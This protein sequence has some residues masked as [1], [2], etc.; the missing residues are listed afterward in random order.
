MRK[1]KF[2]HVENSE[3]RSKDTLFTIS[4]SRFSEKNLL[5]DLDYTEVTPYCLFKGNLSKKCG[6]QF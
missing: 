5:F 3:K 6:T 4:G 1:E 2:C